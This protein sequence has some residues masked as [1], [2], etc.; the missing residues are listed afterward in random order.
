MEAKAQT[1]QQYQYLEELFTFKQEIE[2]MN[3]DF[4]KI[5]EN[6]NILKSVGGDPNCA[7]EN[8]VAFCVFKSNNKKGKVN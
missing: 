2:T 3:L 4:Q 7:R 5:N 8:S 6:E 1:Y